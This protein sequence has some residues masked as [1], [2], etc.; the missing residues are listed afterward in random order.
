[1]KAYIISDTHFN[2]ANI[3]RYCGRPFANVGEMN[4]AIVS[5]WNQA[6]GKDETIYHLGDF[7]FGTNEEI[8][9]LL[10]RLNGIKFLHRGN[11]DYRRGISA[12]IECGFSEVTNKEIIIGRYVLSHYPLH[13]GAGQINI[14]GHIHDKELCGDFDRDTHINVSVDVTDFKPVGFDSS[15]GIIKL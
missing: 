11:H 2:H 14:C 10:D 5:N 13:V 15:I 8:K 7:G 9:A 3:I 12:W 1:M 6:V 4:E